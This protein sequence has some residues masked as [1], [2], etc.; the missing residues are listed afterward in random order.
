MERSELRV[1]RGGYRDR[2]GG[3]GRHVEPDSR[4]G[5]VGGVG[6]VWK[7]GRRCVIGEH[8]RSFSLCGGRRRVFPWYEVLLRIGESLEARCLCLSLF[9][10]VVPLTVSSLG[11]LSTVSHKSRVS[12]HRPPGRGLLTCFSAVKYQRS[13]T[14]SLA[15]LG[16]KG[17]HWPRP[18]RAP[19]PRALRGGIRPYP[20]DF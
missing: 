2:H 5:G 17:A 15:C 7:Q 18:S 13:T 3:P 14:H 6:G 8:L 9:G 11:G 19:P 20:S 1:T 12:C 4:V 16:K 10:K